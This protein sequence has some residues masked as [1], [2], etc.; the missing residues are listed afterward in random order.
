MVRTN[1]CRN[2][3]AFLRITANARGLV[4]AE[5]EAIDGACIEPLSYRLA[6]EVARE[7]VGAVDSE[8]DKEQEAANVTNAMA[9]P[10]KVEALNLEARL[11]V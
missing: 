3:G 2:C 6:Y 4:N 1:S 9:S 7:A 8:E 5:V 11:L 10:E